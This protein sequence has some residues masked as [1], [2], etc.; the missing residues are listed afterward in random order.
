MWVRNLL[1][2]C[3][4]ECSNIHMLPI[5]HLS[6]AMH[7]S[8]HGSFGRGRRDR[9]VDCRH[10]CDNVLDVWNQVLYNELCF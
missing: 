4:S 3:G 1:K 9:A 8:H 5:Y 6:L 2:T 7:N 10:W